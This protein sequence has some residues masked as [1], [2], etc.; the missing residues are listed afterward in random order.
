[1]SL[2]SMRPRRIAVDTDEWRCVWPLSPG[3]VKLPTSCTL[4]T[5]RAA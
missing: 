3:A 5:C 4:N 2:L 1:M